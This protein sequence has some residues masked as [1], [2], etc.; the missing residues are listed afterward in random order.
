METV[1]RDLVALALERASGQQF[2]VFVNEFYPS[3]IGAKF[4]PLGG[5]RDGG[6][7]GLEQEMVYE[8]AGFPTAF[9]QASIQEDHR[10]KIRKTVERL[11]EFRRHPKVDCVHGAAAQVAAR[12][13]RDRI[14]I[15]GTIIRSPTTSTM[16]VGSSTN[17]RMPPTAYPTGTAVR[18]VAR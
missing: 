6:A 12:T 1:S 17:P 14:R 10:R 5:V 8:E 7:D 13:D 4:V 2:E 9:Y 11:R 15:P 18:L 16:A 3:L